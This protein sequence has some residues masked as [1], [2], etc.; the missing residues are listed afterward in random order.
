V[1]TTFRSADLIV[2]ASGRPVVVF[3]IAH[4][5]FRLIAAVHFKMIVRDSALIRHLG[6]QAK[7]VSGWFGEANCSGL[8]IRGGAGYRYT[9]AWGLC[10]VG[11]GG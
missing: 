11:H 1:R 7:S 2:V 6:R 5:R 8:R 9:P 10:G 3:N 4:N